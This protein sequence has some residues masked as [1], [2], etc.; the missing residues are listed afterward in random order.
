M[1]R[2]FP[3]SNWIMSY[4]AHLFIFFHQY[5]TFNLSKWR[6][7]IV[8]CLLKFRPCR[9]SNR[10]RQQKLVHGFEEEPLCSPK[11]SS[12]LYSPLHSLKKN[13]YTSSRS[14]NIDGETAMLEEEKAWIS[15]N[16]EKLFIFLRM[17]CFKL[18]LKHVLQ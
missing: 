7:S 13:I 12:S 10:K 16:G 4:V 3:L 15:T 6:V 9:S 17:L 1:P 11:H 14:G 8:N 5:T 18:K 2:T